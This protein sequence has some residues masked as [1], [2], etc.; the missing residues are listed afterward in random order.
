MIT[1]K[2]RVQEKNYATE[3]VLVYHFEVNGF[4]EVDEKKKWIA[5]LNNAYRFEFNRSTQCSEVFYAK[6]E[7]E[8]DYQSLKTVIE[9]AVFTKN[10]EIKEVEKGIR[11]Q[12]IRFALEN[13]TGDLYKRN[14]KGQFEKLV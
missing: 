1:I 6:A 13:Y 2:Q 12:K 11:E 9:N 14:D 8:A 3:R 10:R 4:M 5:D 7:T